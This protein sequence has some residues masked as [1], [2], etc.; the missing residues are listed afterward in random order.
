MHSHSSLRRTVAQTCI[1]I[2][3]VRDLG[4]ARDVVVLAAPLALT[5]VCT[6]RGDEE[7]CDGMRVVSVA[8]AAVEGAVRGGW[9][10][11]GGARVPDALVIG[12]MEF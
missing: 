6:A 12:R 11:N 5:V 1:A 8:A 2:R 9:R 10:Q 3:S 7:R 4:I